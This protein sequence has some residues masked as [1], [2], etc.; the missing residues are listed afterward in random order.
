MFNQVLIVKSV[1]HFRLLIFILGYANVSTVL[2]SSKTLPFLCDYLNMY[3]SAPKLCPFLSDY[4]NMY[5]SD[6]GFY[7]FLCDYLNMYWSAPK[8][9]PSL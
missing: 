4:L 7:P 1:Y 5:W 2:C 8:L 6:S 3:W 9:C